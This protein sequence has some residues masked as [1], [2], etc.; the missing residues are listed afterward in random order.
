[1]AERARG[2]VPLPST[3]VRQ[4]LINLLLNAVQAAS[5]RGQVRCR[6]ASDETAP[7]S[8]M[9]AT[10]DGRFRREQLEHLFEPFV[11]RRRGSGLGLWV[12]YQIVQQLQGRRSA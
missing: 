10:T 3:P 4:V 8:A 1:M 12:T 7:A 2:S 6:I 5:E 9:C 11:E